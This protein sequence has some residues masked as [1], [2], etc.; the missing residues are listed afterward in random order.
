VADWAAIRAAIATTLDVIDGLR[1]FGYAKEG[2]PP[3]LAVV[4]PG[5]GQFLK[6]GPVEGPSIPVDFTAT[7]EL[8]VARGTD[9]TGQDQLDAYLATTGPSSIY[10]TIDANHK[11]GGVVDYCYV[12][13]AEG[14]TLANLNG[15]D[16]YAVRFS[17]SGSA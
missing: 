9:R 7:V 13:A 11:L 6:F 3:P 14:Y 1:V 16:V 10:A 8:F 12:D 5:Q 15:I 17:L 4:V 2:T